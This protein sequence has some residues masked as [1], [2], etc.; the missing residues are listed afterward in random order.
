[1]QWTWGASPS[2]YLDNPIRKFLCSTRDQSRYSPCQWETSLHCNDISH[3][4][5]AYLHWSLWKNRILNAMFEESINVPNKRSYLSY[6]TVLETMTGPSVLDQQLLGRTAPFHIFPNKSIYLK[7]LIWTGYFFK[8]D[9]H[10]PYLSRSNMLIMR[11][12]VSTLNGVQFPFIRACCSSW[13]EIRPDPSWST[14]CN[15]SMNWS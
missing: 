10:Y 13:A 7:I 3:W 8:L 11:R 12:H 9:Y 14:A 6:R 5:G 15:R 4:L 2:L 1:M